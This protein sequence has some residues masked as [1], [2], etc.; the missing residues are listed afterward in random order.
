V[1]EFR[2]ILHDRIV[3]NRR[4]I[5][6]LLEDVSLELSGSGLCV[7]HLEKPQHDPTDALSQVRTALGGVPKQQKK[8]QRGAGAKEQLKE[9]PIQAGA[10]TTKPIPKKLVP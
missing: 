9:K 1:P 3:P 6:P 4:E 2:D 8:P 10:R 7:V 5:V